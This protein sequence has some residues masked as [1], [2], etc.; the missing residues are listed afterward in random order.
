MTELIDTYMLWLSHIFSQY[1]HFIG[2]SLHLYN[3][4]TVQIDSPAELANVLV[5][6]TDS[7]EIKREDVSLTVG[8]LD[9]VAQST[10]DLQQED[11]SCYNLGLNVVIA[12]MH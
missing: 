7:D 9:T 6:I 2:L 11:V 1:S 5:D 8:L 3:Y 12:I 10:V 4:T